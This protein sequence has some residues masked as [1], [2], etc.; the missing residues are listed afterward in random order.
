MAATKKNSTTKKTS[1]ARKTTEQAGMRSFKL[2]R[3]PV[4]FFAFRVTIQTV[5]WFLLSALVLALGVWVVY[6][7]VK[8]QRVYDQVE[9]NATSIQV[10]DVP[11]R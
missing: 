7:T 3:G 2:F 10:H 4:Y 9:S 8:I 1:A 11:K 5:Y 6:L